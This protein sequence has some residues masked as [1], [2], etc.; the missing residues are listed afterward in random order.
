MYTVQ[1]T[2][3]LTNILKT[4]YKLLDHFNTVRQFLLM[5]AGDAMHTFSCLLFN[6]VS[7]I[8]YMSVHVL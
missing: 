4:D 8:M 3:S 2:T 6:R 7:Y 1:A 5:E